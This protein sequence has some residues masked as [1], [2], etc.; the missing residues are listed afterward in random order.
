MGGFAVGG[1]SF[2]KIF[3]QVQCLASPAQ[4]APVQ[5]APTWSIEFAG[6][7]AAQH[8][9]DHDGFWRFEEFRRAVRCSGHV[10]EF[11]MTN[12]DLRGLFDGIGPALCPPATQRA[13]CKGPSFRTRKRLAE[14]VALGQTSAR[15]APS[16]WR[17][18]NT[19]FLVAVRGYLSPQILRLGIPKF[20]RLPGSARTPNAQDRRLRWIR[21]Q[22]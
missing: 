4:P 20:A 16:R 9:A 18:S 10:T 17:S 6:G 14:L 8:D 2:A 11:A 13:L 3:H 12:T 7:V 5:N 15:S 19:R 1:A 22:R 21:H